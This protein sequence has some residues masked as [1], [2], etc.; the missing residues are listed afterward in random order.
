MSDQDKVTTQPS[1]PS[2]P[3]MR[4]PSERR[5]DEHE[6]AI[7][8]LR[9]TTGKHQALLES[10]V[11]NDRKQDDVLAR[12]EK[13]IDGMGRAVS[14]VETVASEM[15]EAQLSA[16]QEL[17]EARADRIET[18]RLLSLLRSDVAGI[19]SMV[20]HAF[21]S[22]RNA[23]VVTAAVAAGGILF[24]FVFALVQQVFR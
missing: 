19:V 18:H 15:R 9:E 3:D 16:R 22:P 10:V 20:A 4:T 6:T 21:K 17:A 5:L 12:V 13:S 1:M 23:L 14:A 7:N 8:D 2:A 11:L 24:G